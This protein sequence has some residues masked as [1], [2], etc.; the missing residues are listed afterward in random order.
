MMRDTPSIPEAAA[1]EDLYC[2]YCGY[3]L[4]GLS[5]DPRR[6]PECGQSSTVAEMRIPATLIRKQAKKL[7]T[8]PSLCVGAMLIGPQ[9][10]L[11]LLA[12]RLPWAAAVTVPAVLAAWGACAW[13]FASHCDYRPG[14]LIPLAEIHAAAFLFVVPFG[15][16]L[17]G[18]AAWPTFGWN[19]ISVTAWPV[20]LAMLVT[21]GYVYRD[22]RRR[23]VVLQ[24]KAAVDLA[25]Q[26]LGRP[27][28][29]RR[30]PTGLPRDDV[31]DEGP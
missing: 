13:A 8:L 28:P 14:W 24:R 3:N 18:F 10:G 9:V 12:M 19:W 31:S 15:M 11:M 5:G 6:C 27:Q 29:I 26:E 21:G 16:F 7:E 4:R 17:G 20:G 2:L 30:F 22:A 25:R 1:T 23:L